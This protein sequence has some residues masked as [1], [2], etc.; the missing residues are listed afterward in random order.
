MLSYT[1]HDAQS[2]TRLVPAHDGD[3]N[4]TSDGEW[5]YT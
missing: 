3:G 4:M 2:S 5:L 1:C